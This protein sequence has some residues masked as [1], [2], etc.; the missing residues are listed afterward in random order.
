MM[1]G[2]GGEIGKN[3]SIVSGNGN[4]SARTNSNTNTNGE[5]NDGSAGKSGRRR[6]KAIAW[7]VRGDLQPVS[8]FTKEEIESH[9]LSLAEFVIGHGFGPDAGSSFGFGFLFGASAGDKGDG[10]EPERV[11]KEE[12]RSL[13]R[14]GML[15][16]MG[17]QMDEEVKRVLEQWRKEIRVV[18]EKEGEKERSLVAHFETNTSIES[19]P[20]TN[21]NLHSVSNPECSSDAV[22]SQASIEKTSSSIPGSAVTTTKDENK[23]EQKVDEVED[24]EMGELN[25]AGEKSKDVME[26]EDE[27]QRLAV[28][29]DPTAALNSVASA[30]E[31]V[32]SPTPITSVKSP[33]ATNVSSTGSSNSPQVNTLE[34]SSEPVTSTL[35]S[36]PT[37]NASPKAASD[38]TQNQQQNLEQISFSYTKYTHPNPPSDPAN[39]SDYSL[40]FIYLPSPEGLDNKAFDELWSKGEPI[41]V[42]GVNVHVGGGHGPTRPDIGPKMY[43]AFAAL[44][45]PGGFGS[46]RL[47]MDV[48]DAINIMLHASPIPDDSSSQEATTSLDPLST[49]PP[50][51]PETISQTGSKSQPRPGCAVWDIYPAQGADKIR[52]F[53]KEKFGKTHNFVD[54]IHSQ[55]FYLDAKSRNELWERKKVVSWR[56]YQYPVGAIASLTRGMV[57]DRYAWLSARETI[58]RRENEAA[59]EARRKQLQTFQSNDNGSPPFQSKVPTSSSTPTATSTLD[60]NSSSRMGYDRLSMSMGIGER[61]MGM[62]LGRVGMGSWGNVS[63][64]RDEPPRGGPIPLAL[65][66]QS[67]KVSRGE[68]AEDK[69]LGESV[70]EMN[71]EE[72][73]DHEGKSDQGEHSISD[74]SLSVSSFSSSLPLKIAKSLFTLALQRHETNPSE[75]FVPSAAAMNHRPRGPSLLDSHSSIAR[76]QSSS[77][78]L[79]AH[80]VH[81]RSSQASASVRTKHT[82]EKE[83]KNTPPKKLKNPAR[84]LRTSTLIKLGAKRMDEI[85]ELARGDLGEGETLGNALGDLGNFA[86]LDAV[87]SHG[88]MQGWAGLRAISES[89]KSREDGGREAS[90]LLSINDVH[91][92][93]SSPNAEADTS[94]PLDDAIDRTDA[95]TAADIAAEILSMDI[96]HQEHET[97]IEDDGDLE[98]LRR[99]VERGIL[100]QG[101][102][103]GEE[104]EQEDDER[105]NELGSGGG[106]EGERYSCEGGRT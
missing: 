14:E 71:K 95:E 47:H 45:T 56:V 1:N 50:S 20:K 52:E 41:V 5:R 25:N 46:T 59:A 28:F 26:T 33:V 8:R 16:V 73:E 55:M 80:T 75:L 68:V 96:D 78:P 19:N 38:P 7:H 54:P 70:S 60:L 27:E 63:S 11:K 100:E 15:R 79:S 51:S 99:I 83:N 13:Q 23:Q 49:P 105:D 88:G 57:S 85:L 30:S 86:E 106:R 89:S 84:P 44:E 101:Q 91:N 6:E 21:T 72:K 66:G 77:R 92:S 69:G 40:P 104:R 74:S 39:L 62:G 102:E 53:L 29:T 17:L 43:A 93:N 4:G 94:M 98:G 18:R 31:I 65:N 37:S 2:G 42:G 76:P 35:T 87:E 34:K 32:R 58:T 22:D 103:Q 64:V 81:G 97:N 48:A 36:I 82:K 10:D 90:P 67:E 9:W 3:D 24:L 61:G 12:E